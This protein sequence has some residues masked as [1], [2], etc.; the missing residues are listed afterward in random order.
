MSR[1]CL[2]GAY[3]G[4]VTGRCSTVDDLR[5]KLAIAEELARAVRDGIQDILDNIEHDK[6]PEVDCAGCVLREQ[7][8]MVLRACP[9]KEV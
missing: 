3:C 5:A 8:E 7:L 4:C 2:A 1:P 6:S 9:K